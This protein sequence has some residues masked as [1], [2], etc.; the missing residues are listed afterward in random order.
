MRRAPAAF[1]CLRLFSVLGDDSVDLAR[2]MAHR[3][4][5]RYG[6]VTNSLIMP[7]P[8]RCSLAATYLPL[9]QYQSFQ[10]I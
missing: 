9:L 7:P 3:A 8:A 10:L 5:L 6:I 1:L 4:L 2:T